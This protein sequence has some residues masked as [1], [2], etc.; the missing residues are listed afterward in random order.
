[1]KILGYSAIPG[2]QKPS[3]RNLRS[4]T[5]KN[6]QEI[7]KDSLNQAVTSCGHCVRASIAQR[8]F[9]LCYARFIIRSSQ[10]PGW[11]EGEKVNLH[12][13]VSHAILLLK[14]LP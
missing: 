2:G 3:S 1:M 6:F 14:F 5:V 8:T 9:E 12:A 13:I 7:L 10:Q 4:I 11:E